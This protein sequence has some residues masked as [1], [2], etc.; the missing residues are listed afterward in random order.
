MRY[1]QFVYEDIK[2]NMYLRVTKLLNSSDTIL[3]KF[4]RF[5]F[6]SSHTHK[7]VFYGFSSSENVLVC[8]NVL[9]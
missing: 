8:T 7:K 3:I 6:K 2:V 9:F 4:Y 5:I 1:T